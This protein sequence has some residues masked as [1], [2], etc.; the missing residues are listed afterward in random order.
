MTIRT[1]CSS[2]LVSLNEACAAVAKGDCRSAIVGGTS[3]VTAPS[4]VIDETNVG[5]LSPDGSC[6]TFSSNADG[7][8]RGEGIVALYIKPLHDALRDGNPV[9]AVIVGA[10]T[11][12]DGKTPGFTVPSSDA[13]ESLIRHAYKIAGISESDI[14]K[15]GFIEC[16]G[17]GTQR[18]DITETTAIRKV[19]AGSDSVHIGSVKPNLGHG[20]GVSGLTALLKAVL[21]L[22][23]RTILPNI[24]CLPF[25][26]GIPLV[27]GPLVVPQ[28]PT[29]WPDGCAERVSVNSFGIG[30]S[31]AHIILDSAKI[32]GHGSAQPRKRSTET[33]QLLIYSA[34]SLQSLKEMTGRYT[35]YLEDIPGSIDITDVAYTLANRREHLSFRSFTVRTRHDPGFTS[36]PASQPRTGKVSLAM[37]FTGQGAQWPQMGREL[38]RNNSVFT[39][40]IRSLDGHLQS[41]GPT[42]PSWKIEDELLRPT[43]TTRVND[44]EFSQPLCTALQ[45]ALVDTLASIRIE[46]TAVVGHSSGEI[47]AAYAAHGLTSREAI[48]IAFYRGLVSKIQT[49]PGGMAAVNLSCQE[50]EKFLI[51][52]TVMAC[53]NSPNSV[54]ISGD[55]LRVESVLREIKKTSPAVLTT[56]LNVD[57]AYHSDHMAEVGGEYHCAMTDAGITGAKPLISFFS[58]VYGGPIGNDDGREL[59]DG[60]IFGPRYWQKNLESPVL[61][62]D[63]V[64]SLLDHTLSTSETLAFLEIG[65]HGALAGPLRQIVAGHSSNT[66]DPPQHIRTISRRQNSQ[67]TFLTAVGK[68]WMLGA[69][70]DFN[71]LIPQGKCVPD[72]PRYPWYHPRTYWKE[73]R[74]VR[75]WRLRKYPYHDLLGARVPESSDIEPVWRNLLHLD[76]VPWVR[77]HKIR[78][79][80]I[81]PFAGYVAMA[82]EGA[83]QVSGIPEAVELRNVVVTTA[84]VLTEREPT[85]LLT[86]LRRHRLTDSMDSRWWEFT[87]SAYNGHVWTKHCQGQVCAVKKLTL[88]GDEVLDKEKALVHDVNVHQWYERVSRGSLR[89]GPRFQTMKQI[90][91]TASGTKGSGVTEISN[92][93]P[94]GENTQYHLHPV[95]LDTFFQIAGAAVHH[96][97]THA[98]RQAIPSRM[99]YIALIRCVADRFTLSANCAPV[100]DSFVGNGLG[101]ASPDS[102]PC[103]KVS[104]AHLS[105]IDSTE[106]ANE[107]AVS[108]TARCVWVPHIDFMDLSALIQ[109]RRDHAAYFHLLEQLGQMAI[110]LYRRLLNS[111][112]PENGRSSTQKYVAW[113]R[114]QE[115]PSMESLDDAGLLARIHDLDALVTNSPAEPAATAITKLCLSATDVLSEKREALEILHH[116]GNLARFLRFLNKYDAA[117]F[118]RCQARSQPGI[119]ILEIGTGLGPSIDDFEHIKL[120]GGQLLYSQYVYTERST[121]PLQVAKDRCKD[122]SNMEF[123]VLDITRDPADQGFQGRQFDLV[124]ANGVINTTKSL[125]ESLRHVR[126]LIDDGGR[127]LFQQPRGLSWTKFVLGALPHW[128]CSSESGQTTEPSVELTG[129]DEALRAAGF[130]GVDGEVPDAPD[131]FHVNS[132]MLAKPARGSDNQK[133]KSVTILH[134]KNDSSGLTGLVESL[135]LHGFSPSCCTIDSAPADRDIIA[136]LDKSTAFFERIEDSAFSRLRDL[137][138]RINNSESGILWVTKPTQTSCQD[139]KYAPVIGLARTLRAELGVDFATCEVDDLTASTTLKAL[140]DVFHEFH[141]RSTSRI[142]DLEFSITAGLTRVNRI[143]P[144]SLDDGI[145][146]WSD[147]CRAAAE[148][149]RP[150]RLESLQWVEKPSLSLGADEIEIEV[151]AVGLNFR[152]SP[153][154]SDSACMLLQLLARLEGGLLSDFQFK[155]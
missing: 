3:I 2:S 54:T 103:L 9:R 14:L 70:V 140:G 79:D 105:P 129:W 42:A 23:N 35:S 62:K 134:D 63:A 28:K 132:V 147:H 117:E 34:E 137:V 33:P 93:W 119:R 46:P 136:V 88:H 30:G 122:F 44:A 86:T 50:V 142:M 12:C 115:P 60:D 24:K 149:S 37:I 74:A 123:A 138:E 113:L 20:E 27:N 61:F 126:A 125:H 38:L 51:P 75:E 56:T 4:L 65:P 81:F 73:N 155:S 77:D 82:A 58:S 104:G 22:E 41:L 150:G 127:L 111:N 139:P 48:I 146:P 108:I 118:L 116:E 135:R 130:R 151:H 148:I 1:A 18:G 31:N 67:E 128:W 47:A 99:D 17:T 120:P 121:V 152:V 55:S 39:Q 109:P 106:D 69:N 21:S 90:K 32:S 107:D 114:R 52:G 83:Y 72:L 91:T 71:A 133:S 144:S 7:Y 8:G 15:T 94:A 5:T 40:T 68:L 57:K 29:K 66:K 89:Y 43:R 98:Y 97:F 95:V 131:P 11:N 153:G 124:L 100:D 36:P 49:R 25:N 102:M 45:I 143:F 6:K 76:S 16:H 110:S 101:V 10:A 87:V 85:E 53:D 26:A 154:Y 96:G 64:S 92:D 13:Q 84:L 59:L 78:T 145:K 19:F 80:I 112:V 141:G